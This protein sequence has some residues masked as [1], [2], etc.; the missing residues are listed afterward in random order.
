MAYDGNPQ[1]AAGVREGDVIA[2]KYRIEKVL[3]VGGMGAVVAAHHL[4][5]DSKVAIKFLL[6]QTLSHPDA[7]T[8]FAN[9][10]R[11]LRKIQSEHVARVYDVGTLENCAPYMV[12]EYLEGSDL[13]ALLA[14]QGPLALDE[15]IDF[16][17]Q[18]M[19]AIAEA[20]ALG[21]VHRDLK[22]ANLFCIRGADGKPFVKVLDFGISKGTA[23]GGPSG[24]LNR[25]ATASVMGSPFYMSPEQM[26]SARGVDARTDVWA[27]GVILFE[28]TTGNVPFYGQTI[29]EVCS[30]IAT[31]PAP[32]LRESLPQAPEG[33]EVLIL[34]CLEKDRERR[35]P[36]LAELAS[37]LSPFSPRRSKASIEK[38]GD[39]IRAAGT[40]V[41]SQR[42]SPE[43]K[44]Q[45]PRIATLES[46]TRTT[47]GTKDTK[48]RA[49]VSAWLQGGAGLLA[50]VGVALGVKHFLFEDRA[51]DAGGAGLSGSA[52]TQAVAPAA[53]PAP[54]A[55]SAASN[56]C[57]PGATRCRGPSLETCNGKDWGA[58]TVTEGRCGAVCTPESS[59]SRCG[60]NAVVRCDAAGQWAESLLC[61]A[62]QVCQDAK[63]VEVQAPKREH[64]QP[65]PQPNRSCDP[66]YTIDAKTGAHKFK[67]S[68][69]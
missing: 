46:V 20:H 55:Q 17:L 36:N 58:A 64:S 45:P 21:I 44:S 25:T 12:M 60:G 28:L 40:S 51:K 59:P 5:L 50:L 7:V 24:L 15:A 69:E 54:A 66:P 19:E 4:E 43:P 47:F 68:C 18:A 33:L 3:G 23:A 38:I 37:A 53:P 6:P 14:Q 49:G 1:D 52:A 32:K 39:I 61:G 31:R 65:Q 9:E 63:C 26:D 62:S 34:T 56:A 57:E 2:G 35:Y 41:V 30:R 11:R 16:V 22:P 67:P 10:A 48:R 42:S 8:R 13:S 27:L 29:P